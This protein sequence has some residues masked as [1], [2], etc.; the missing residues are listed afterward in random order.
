MLNPLWYFLILFQSLEISFILLIKCSCQEYGWSSW[1]ET[2]AK[3]DVLRNYK[4]NSV[5][6]A[7]GLETNELILVRNMFSL[8]LSYCIFSVKGGW[9]QL[10]DTTNFLLLKIEQVEILI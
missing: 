5:A 8:V 1:L 3:L 9:H 6:K 2:S 4:S 7:D 10:E